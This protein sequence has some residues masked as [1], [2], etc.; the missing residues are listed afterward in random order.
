VVLNPLAHERT[1]LVEVTG[2]FTEV[3]DPATGQR[4]AVE[5]ESRRPAT[6]TSTTRSRLWLQGLSHSP[7]LHPP[8]RRQHWSVGATTLSNQFYKIEFDS[9]TGVIRSIYDK[10]LKRELV[11]PAARHGFNQLVD[12][13]KMSREAKEG[14]DYSPIRATLRL[15]TGWLRQRQLYG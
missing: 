2:A 14:D 15:R 8:K 5:A 4:I 1:D 3:I 6:L 9:Q 11:D 13:H 12:V 10:E 7:Y